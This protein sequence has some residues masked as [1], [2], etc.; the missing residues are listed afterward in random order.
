[1]RPLLVIFAFALACGSVCCGHRNTAVTEAE[2]VDS[3]PLR[4][5]RIV[6]VGD[7]MVHTPQIAKA[8]IGNYYDFTQTFKYV[9]PIFEEADLVVANLE[10]T[11]AEM[12]PY[13]GYP[14][15]RSPA[16]VADALKKAGVDAVVMANNHTLDYGADG[17]RQ[18]LRILDDRGIMY[19]GTFADSTDYIANNPLFIERRG[20]RV[21]ILNYT[22]G[23]NGIPVRGG[24]IVNHIDTATILK[25]VARASA[26]DCIIAYLHWGDEYVRHENDTQRRV[27]EFFH[28]NGVQAVIGSHPHVVQ[29]Y[30][31]TDSTV[32]VYS[33][34]NFVSNQRK[35]YC[36]GGLIATLDISFV[37]DSVAYALELM[38]AWVR[39]ADYAVIPQCVGDTL[40]MSRADSVAYS[41]FMAD[42]AELLGK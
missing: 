33:L 10:T 34:G 27:A 8:Y 17:V 19:T 28:R 20:V 26:A 13:T 32:A 6:F 14:R 23:T 41:R 15:F 16:T 36:D 1:M 24:I 4:S 22:Y 39:L 37:G 42:T 35:R 29:P 30:D 5:I 18:T 31:Q 3:I 12:P 40:S 11:L 38:P 21:A 25:D 7:V 9:K 2:A